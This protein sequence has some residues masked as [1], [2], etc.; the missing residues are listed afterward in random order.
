MS[1]IVTD[2]YKVLGVKRGSD[3]NTIRRAFRQ[4][5][6]QYHPDLNPAAADR[7][8][9]ITA[10]YD[11]LGDEGKRALYD[12]FGNVSLKPGFDPVVARHAG[13][14]RAAPAGGGS[15][16]EF[17][18]HLGGSSAGTRPYRGSAQESEPESS[19][20]SAAGTRP[21]QGSPA[22]DQASS[23]SEGSAAGTRPYQ[24]S[25]GERSEPGAY[26][27]G[28]EGSAAGTRPYRGSARGRS[29]GFSS[30]GRY[31]PGKHYG[32]GRANATPVPNPYR[33]RQTARQPP[34]P[35]KSTPQQPP[36]RP[37]SAERSFTSRQ[38]PSA[39]QRERLYRAGPVPTQGEDISLTVSLSLL[40]S[41]RGGSREVAIER[42]AAD[43]RRSV[44]HLR[45]RLRAGVEDGEQVLIR[46]KG[47]SGR[48]G[49][50]S[51]NLTV[52]VSVESS[53]H[54]RR[55]GHDLFIDVP[56]T[57]QEAIIGGQ[58]EVPTP[59]GLVRVRVPGGSTH[60]R[61]LRLRGRG[62]SV[63]N[64]D[65]GDLYLILR[66]TPPSSIDPEVIRMI[67]ELEKYYPREGV[68]ATLKL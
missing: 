65:R 16:Q 21:Y 28:F 63:G 5:A 47:H 54:F 4:L 12:E 40:E 2:F 38:S 15:F 53:P 35:P 17:F 26:Q 68:R 8:K 14:G 66:P 11:V 10:A 39:T 42:T 41:L 50:H 36:Q 51:G 7:F 44:E 59:N 61:R 58:I 22:Q 32:D 37:S 25:P 24:G 45:I 18:G 46:G 6:R 64:G 31:H 1:D 52:Q 20:K 56:V 30:N 67:A 49:G 27:S 29:A 48:H 33:T 55:Q 19:A 13:L 3:P 9:E 62:V 43:G 60:G 34:P 57:L 23:A